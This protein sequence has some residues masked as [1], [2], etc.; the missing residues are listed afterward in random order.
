LELAARSFYAH[1]DARTPLYLAALNV[2]VYLILAI[3]LS[4]T[5]GANG[6]ALAN[7]IA[8]TL[9]AIALLVLLRMRFPGI[10]LSWR[11]VG[12]TALTVSLG[13]AVTF[14]LLAW[15]PLHP[16]LAGLAA[17]AA[18]GLVV[19]PLGWPTLRVLL[20]LGTRARL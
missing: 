11:E 18:G 12:R 4:Q 6:I 16:L 7:S 10:G 9:E 3:G 19:L 13:S 15:L 14:G 1:Q 5:L 2:L 17:A 20:Q 8:F